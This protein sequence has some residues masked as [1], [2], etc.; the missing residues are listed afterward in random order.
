[1]QGI[2]CQLVFWFLD[3]WEMMICW[4]HV[5]LQSLP[6]EAFS[7]GTSKDCPRENSRVYAQAQ[8]PGQGLQ[9]PQWWLHE[10]RW[11][12]SCD[13][14]SMAWRGCLVPALPSAMPNWSLSAHTDIVN[15]FSRCSQ[16]THVFW[17]T[18]WLTLYNQFTT[19]SILGQ[20][21]PGAYVGSVGWFMLL[22]FESHYSSL[23]GFITGTKYMG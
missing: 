8:G 3:L 19:M 7:P 16:P 13:V 5:V 17:L 10:Q 22:F 15:F 11:F 18:K 23:G 21:C 14:F 1:M 9:S 6:T 20:F 2:R 4:C 12:L